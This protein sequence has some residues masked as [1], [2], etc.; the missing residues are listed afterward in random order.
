MLKKPNLTTEE[1]KHL[2]EEILSALSG[3]KKTLTSSNFSKPDEVVAVAP[4]PAAAKPAVNPVKKEAAPKKEAASAPPPETAALSVAS[5]MPR[6]ET[7]IA[8]LM[9]KDE[10]TD[11][12]EVKK[13]KHHKSRSFVVIP[14]VKVKAKKDRSDHLE[15]HRIKQ[16]LSMLRF[17]IF[18]LLVIAVLLTV[19]MFLLGLK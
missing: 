16:G 11:K 6:P 10:K 4:P 15:K 12:K 14:E 13:Q 7:T 8:P 17:I 1:K 2:K 3:D 18:L 9:A 5:V 19:N